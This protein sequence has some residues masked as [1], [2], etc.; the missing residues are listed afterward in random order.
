MNTI[1]VGI[2]GAGKTTVG[3]L[4]AE[5]L[6]R[7]FVDTDDLIE[8]RFGLPPLGARDAVADPMLDLFDFRSPPFLT[9]PAL[10]DA[11]VDQSRLCG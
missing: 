10:P 4:L 5:R 2:M 6:G 1:L 7:S 8:T 11:I 3:R 9:P